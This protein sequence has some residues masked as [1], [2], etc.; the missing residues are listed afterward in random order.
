MRRPILFAFGCA[1]L[2][3]GIVGILPSCFTVPWRDP[4]LMLF[5]GPL[6]F[7]LRLL[8]PFCGLILIA[9]SLSTQL[10]NAGLRQMTRRRK[11]SREEP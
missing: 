7:L 4:I 1:M 3:L 11:S 6:T 9:L 5:A 10:K 8:I 2:V